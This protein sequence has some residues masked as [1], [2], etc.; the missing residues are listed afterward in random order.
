MGIDSVSKWVLVFCMLSVLGAQL[1]HCSV[2]YDRKAIVINGQ[3]RILISGSI[4]Y[5]RS[6]PEMWEDLINKAKEGGLDVIETYVF[7]NVHEP[8]PGNYNFEGRYDLVRFMKIIQKAGLYA[9]LRIGPYVCAEWNFGGFPVWLK[10]VPGISF[11]TD[12]GPFKMHMQR[13]TEKIV[14]LMKSENL[15]ESQGGPII[16]SQIENEYGPQVKVLGPPAQNYVNWAAKMAVGLDTGVPWVMCKEEDAPDPVINTCNGF[17]C[18]AFTPNRPYKPTI[19]TEAWSGWFTEFGGT[20]PQRP[21]QD[22]AFAVARFI[23]KGGSLVN[24]YMYH[25]GTNF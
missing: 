16:L 18:D 10:Y 5:P 3:R 25:G 17:Y 4:H 21:V 22:L 6:T 19:W 9:H 14:S 2:T 12:N 23:Q 24:Y 20:I 11:R 13:F 8:S 1:I 15:Y 7:W